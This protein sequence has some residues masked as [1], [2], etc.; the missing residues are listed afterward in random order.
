MRNGGELNNLENIHTKTVNRDY[1]LNAGARTSRLFC[2][3]KGHS[4]GFERTLDR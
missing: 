2:P 1:L 4:S 3:F